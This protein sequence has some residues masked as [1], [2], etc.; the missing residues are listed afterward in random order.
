MR[1][2]LDINYPIEKFEQ[3]RRRMEARLDFTYTD[4]VP[5]AFCLA[6]RY[7][8]PIFGI[9][10]K[11]YFKDVETQFHWQLQF[12]KYRMENIPEDVWGSP[13][14]TVCPYFDN[15]VNA[16]AL[17]A[18]IVWTDDD[19][20]R[21]SP[22]IKTPDDVDRYEIP[23]PTSGLWGKI[24]EWNF[25]MREL[26]AE[27]QITFNGKPGK[28]EVCPPMI[29]GEGPHMMAIDL[30]GED[31]YWWMAECPEVC[32]NLL[33]KITKAMIQAE[34]NFRRV[35]PAPRLGFGLAE[36]SAQIMSEAMFK[37]F[38]VPYDSAL[39][40]KYGAG[41]IDGRGMHM[42]GD[43]I[44]L[45][46][47]LKEDLRIS[48][49]NVFGYMVPPELAAKNLGGNIYLWGN[50]NPMLM[51]DGTKDEVKSE[52]F[53]CLEGMAPCGGFML[54]DGANIC[55]GTSLENLVAVKEASEEYGKPQVDR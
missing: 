34:D 35:V 14:V 39:Y 52:A 10:Y 23:E 19:P 11:E 44:H 25:R 26:A 28:I 20:P 22:T 24:L 37:E 3:N 41:L 54:G 46:R 50:I 21:A 2:N 49:F 47:S 9:A 40:D 42:C 53:R 55:P 27:T 4:R 38:C 13:V 32:H 5:V 31:F 29:G 8:T 36:D 45:H 18:E 1:F 7:F 15:V 17:G 33:D 51:L 48:S 12:A 43:S 6:P 30:V 16:D